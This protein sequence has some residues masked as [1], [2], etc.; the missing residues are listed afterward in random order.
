MLV[1]T[2]LPVKIVRFGCPG[3]AAQDQKSPGSSPGQRNSRPD[4]TV[5]EVGFALS[6][7]LGY[8]PITRFSVTFASTF[9]TRLTEAAPGHRRCVAWTGIF[10]VP[11][12]CCT[13][14]AARRGD[15][16]PAFLSGA[17]G[18]WRP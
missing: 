4:F 2:P 6:T 5:Y 9:P 15:S 3:S 1:G 17:G 13:C 12:K 16:V 14:L 8:A 18:L 11:W 10:R 7:E